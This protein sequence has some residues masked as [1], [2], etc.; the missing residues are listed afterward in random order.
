MQTIKKSYAN[1]VMYFNIKVK[2]DMHYN[3]NIITNKYPQYFTK[4]GPKYT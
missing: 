3:E 2:A 1:Y 4:Q